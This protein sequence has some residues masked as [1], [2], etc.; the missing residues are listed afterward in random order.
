MARSSWVALMV[1]AGLAGCGS[2]ARLSAG[3]AAELHGQVDAARAAARDGDRAGALR[4]LNRLDA[5]VRRAE[6]DDEL[7]GDD[8]D[9]LRRGVAQA[10]AQVRREVPAPA[11]T[12][13]TS[14]TPAPTQVA[15]EL[16]R[17]RVEHVVVSTEG[18]WL[19]ELG[20]KLR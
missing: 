9:A 2:D 15:A 3:A 13:A 18:D 16:R 11:P 8:A 1:A 7:S 20:R 6:A 5:G 19:F 4:A 12:P 10:K 17:L 14:E